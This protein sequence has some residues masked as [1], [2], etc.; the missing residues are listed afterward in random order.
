MKVIFCSD[1]TS[2]DA[3]DYFFIDELAAASRAGLTYELLHYETLVD[4]GNPARA[5]R[6]IPVQP[7]L[8]PAIYRGWTLRVEQYALLYD[9]LLSRRIRLIHDEI[10]YR[11]TQ[12]LPQS[13][14]AI[15]DYSP[16]T[17]WTVTDRHPNT[18][19]LLTMLLPFSG[20]PIM[21]RDFVRAQKHYW[22]E[23]CY[24]HSASDRSAVER[25]TRR[26]LELQGRIEGG[27]VYREYVP[28]APLKTSHADALSPPEISS[29]G[30]SQRRG[31][32]IV[33]EY[34]LTFVAGRPVSVQA[35][36]NLPTTE[37][38]PP[39]DALTRIAHHIRSRFFTMD[40][41]QLARPQTGDDPLNGWLIL[42]LGDGQVASLSPHSDFDAI[43][44]A[45]SRLVSGTL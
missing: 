38:P 1:P 19:Q 7:Y 17:I 15:K 31:L 45:L 32:P 23:A 34:R 18:D 25:T 43:Y 39:V 4:L 35:R 40:V 26:F 13:L 3:V 16:Q 33:N 29:E 5:V 21:I 36:N 24:I 22:S 8:T 10:A 14:P 6:D 37:D 20:R 9:A 27:L 12:Y 2:Y 30:G 42:E 44:L 28:L 41:A 11:H